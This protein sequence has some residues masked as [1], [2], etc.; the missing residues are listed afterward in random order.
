[1]MRGQCR[2]SEAGTHRKV[3]TFRQRYCL[4]CRQHDELRGRAIGTAPGRVPD[5][6]ALP[7][8]RAIDA[9]AYLVDDAGA[10]AVRNDARKWQCPGPR[11]G[12][13]LDVRWIDSGPDNL[14]ANFY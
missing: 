12:S 7:D 1:M 3:D 9:L 10:V 8:P 5:P 4:G 14:H 2:N 13:R 11:A 6:D